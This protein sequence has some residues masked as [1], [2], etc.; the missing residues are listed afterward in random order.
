MEIAVDN[1]SWQ[2]NPIESNKNPITRRESLR[3]EAIV[4]RMGT[5]SID[6]AEVKETVDIE[7]KEKEVISFD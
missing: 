6:L 5:K 7:V 4:D 1:Q 2:V 3:I